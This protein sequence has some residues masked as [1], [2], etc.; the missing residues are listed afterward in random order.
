MDPKLQTLAASAFDNVYH[1]GHLV[2]DLVSAMQSLAGAMQIT[3]APPFEMR[4]GFT[5][6]DGSSDDQP[7]RLAFSTSG[8]P[9]LELIEVVPAVDSIFAEPTLGGMHHIG[10]YAQRWRDDAARL[11]DEGWELERTGA[12]VAFL[13]DPRSGLRVEVVSVK[14]R[15]F[16]SRVLSGEMA[17]TYPLTEHP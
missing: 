10:Y 8:P 7:V 4:S 2:P 14:G 11:Q 12:G 5:R 6:P 13:R 1:V 17:E 3:W 15:D 16:L 9:Y